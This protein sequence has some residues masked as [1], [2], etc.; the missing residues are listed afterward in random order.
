MARARVFIAPGSLADR[1]RTAAPSGV[2][3]TMTEIIAVALARPEDVRAELGRL[4]DA[5]YIRVYGQRRAMRYFWRPRRTGG[6]KAGDGATAC[7]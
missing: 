7:C 5:G 3:A 6:R 1:I 4:R 2:G